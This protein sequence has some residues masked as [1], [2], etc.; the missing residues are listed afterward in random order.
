MEKL[1][2]LAEPAAVSA[3]APSLHMPS[4]GGFKKTLA[5][6]GLGAAGAM[7]LGHMWAHRAQQDPLVYAPMSGTGVQ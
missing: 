2:V 5:L 7:G 3:A 4:M 1:A 6:T